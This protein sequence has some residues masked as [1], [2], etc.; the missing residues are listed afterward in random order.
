MPDEI[1]A[2]RVWTEDV[3]PEK[4]G[5]LMAENRQC[6]AVLSAEGGIFGIMAGRYSKGAPNIDIFLKGHA[7]EPVRVDRGSREPVNQ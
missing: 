5:T 3:T 6:M 4:L 1:K 2:P 7:G